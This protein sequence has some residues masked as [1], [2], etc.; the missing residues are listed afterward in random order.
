MTY[1]L[2]AAITSPHIRPSL[3]IGITDGAFAV[4]GFYHH[5]L[6]VSRVHSCLLLL[7]LLL[8]YYLFVVW[9]KSR[10][11]KSN[12][13]FCSCPSKSLSQRRDTNIN[14]I[15]P[16][17]SRSGSEYPVWG[18]WGRWGSNLKR[19]RLSVFRKNF[20]PPS[21]RFE[22]TPTS[23]TCPTRL[24]KRIVGNRQKVSQHTRFGTS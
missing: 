10:S 14:L 12:S 23:P 18:K 5:I 24:K 19:R 20:Y 9:Y 22:N 1:I 3:Y 7:L 6:F 2:H 15:F 11:G 16:E 21:G 8:L 4:R 17:L 13:I